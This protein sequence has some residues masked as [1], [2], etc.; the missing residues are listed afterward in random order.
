MTVRTRFAPSPTGALHLGGGR[1]A[2]FNWLYARNQKGKF[3]LRIEDTDAERSTQESVDEILASLSWLGLNWDE[4][5]FYQSQR[6]ALYEE[7]V[8]QL[9]REGKAYR[10]WC[11]KEELDA[12]RAALEAAG[13]KP[14][15]DRACRDRTDGDLSQPHVIRL[16]APLTGVTS[17]V[18]SLRGV[19]E[20]RN[21]ELDDL[22]IR[23]SGG[24][25]IY[26]FVVVIDDAGMGVTH[27][28]RGDDHL[29]NTPKQVLLYK[30]L[31]Y[32]VPRFT[33][34]SMIL[35]QD[36]K[37]LSKRHGAESV[38]AYREMGYLPGALINGLARMGWGC[39]DQ[40]VF[41]RQELVEKFSLEKITMSPAV[42]DQSKLEWL[43]AQHIKL[44]PDAELARLALPFLQKSCPAATEEKLVR[45]V[46]L[47]KER[48][49][50]LLEM[51]AGAEWYF[52]DTVSYDP[53]AAAKFLTEKSRPVL[54][55]AAGAVAAAPEL[56]HKALGET[57]KAMAASLGLGLK[58]IAQ[59]VRV[60]LTG[61]AVSPGVFEMMEL[62][63]KE[64]T[65]RRLTAA[66]RSI[67]G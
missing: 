14:M 50:T 55:A 39:G 63:G 20:F 45:I 64:E 7:K 66:A 46:P 33:H 22:I 17:F 24:G 60:A 4:G 2:L 42:F 36:K 67:G 28:I 13:K 26:N 49:R 19:V 12:K 1:T 58:D 3:I 11:S 44:T 23:R 29:A 52:I 38:I 27:V 54:E 57:F 56:E 21:E 41:T 5:P 6:T 30:A 62:L 15:Y 31:G 35:G 53:Q 18:D 48:S 47:L 32:E 65:G 16:K 43:N 10:C 25:V 61:R 59:P 37:R 9:L 40:E 8:E 34:V 51:A